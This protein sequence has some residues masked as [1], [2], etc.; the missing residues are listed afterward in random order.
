MNLKLVLAV[1]LF[2]AVPMIAYAQNNDSAEKAPKPT[3]ADAQKL[4]QMISS[5][6]AKLK[7]Y[8]DMGKLQEQMEQADQK[9]DDK[10]LEALSAKLDSLTQQIGPEYVKVMEG[11]EEIDPDSAEGK[12]FDAVFDSLT[13]QCK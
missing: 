1:S 5:D 2:A 3:M 4:A 12:R 6:K 13:K 7:A 9:K 11:L 10:A 8:C